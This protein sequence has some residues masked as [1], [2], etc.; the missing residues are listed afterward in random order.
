MATPVQQKS[1]SQQPPPQQQPDKPPTPERIMQLAWGYAPPLLIEA[2]VR[3]GVFDTLDQGPLLAEQLASR[4]N[5]SPRGLRMLLNALVAIQLLRRDA[6]GRYALT[7]ESATFLVGSKPSFQGGIF[8]HISTQLMPKWIDLTE[9]VRTGKPARGVNK[10]EE[11]AAFFE[12]FVEDIFPMSYPAAQA[13]GKELNFG[14][15]PAKVLDIAAGSGVWGIA[16]AQA[17]PQAHVTAVDWEGVLPVTR[18]VAGRFGVGNRF[19]YVA[20]DIQTVNLGSGHDVATL[21]HI[22]HSEGEARSRSLLKR[23]FDALA[24]GGTI[25]IAE[26]VA[27]DDRTGPPNAL[28]FAVNMLVNTDEGDT[29][30]FAELSQWLRE[31]GFENPRTLDAP[32][33]SPLLLATKPR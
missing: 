30:T 2:A 7:E 4:T 6:S 12:K 14:N 31:A 18:R 3:H 25:A 29:F 23:V 24:P 32:G 13:L 10:S 26:F 28:I 22:L 19:N 16:L 9:I 11:G 27:N 20:G 21:G 1:S 8:R 5:T 17:W 15:K 33:P